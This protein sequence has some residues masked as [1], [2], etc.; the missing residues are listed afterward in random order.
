MTGA[1]AGSSRTAVRPKSLADRIVEIA[2]N[3]R[4][5]PERGA[6]AQLKA[7]QDA[8]WGRNFVLNYCKLIKNWLRR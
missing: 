8:D 7:E 2:R 6:A 5:V 1:K 3:R 4:E